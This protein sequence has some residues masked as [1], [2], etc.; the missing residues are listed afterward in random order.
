MDNDDNEGAPAA[1]LCQPKY[2]FERSQ[3]VYVNDIDQNNPDK[4]KNYFGRINVRE[5]DEDTDK[6]I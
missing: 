6:N 3:K 4:M 5:Y 2:K 1:T